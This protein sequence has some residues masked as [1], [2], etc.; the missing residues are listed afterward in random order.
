MGAHVAKFALAIISPLL[1]SIEYH[2]KKW[3]IFFCLWLYHYANVDNVTYY[4]VGKRNLDVVKL[5]IYR[6]SALQILLSFL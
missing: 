1:P 5:L 2:K 6:C 3:F 4:A